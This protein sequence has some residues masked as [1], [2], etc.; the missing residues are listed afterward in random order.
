VTVLAGIVPTAL[1]SALP[2]KLTVQPRSPVMEMLRGVA[3]LVAVP[4]L[5]VM[6]V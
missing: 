2:S 6:V 3:S 1:T 4:A 5:P